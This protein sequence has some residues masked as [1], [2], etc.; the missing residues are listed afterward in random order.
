MQRRLEGIT[1]DAE[2]N[3]S[4]PWS[5]RSLFVCSY[6]VSKTARAGI[7]TPLSAFLIDRYLESLKSSLAIDPFCSVET[8]ALTRPSLVDD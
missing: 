5:M 8:E 1:W 2:R 6:D 7:S 4:W 3:Q